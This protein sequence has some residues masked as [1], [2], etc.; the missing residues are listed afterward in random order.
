MAY[1]SLYG[2]LCLLL[3]RASPF[4]FRP[5]GGA[6]SRW[7]IRWP[8]RIRNLLAAPI[9]RLLAAGLILFMVLL[10]AEPVR[11]AGLSTAET[12]K[13]PLLGVVRPADWSLAALAVVFGLVDGFNPCA[14]WA[15]VYLLSLLV[16]L[17][18]R[19]RI[20]LLAGTFLLASGTLYFFF[21]AAWLNIFLALGYLRLL[22]IAIGAGALGVGIANLREVLRTRGALACHVQTLHSRQ[23]TSGRIEAIVRAPLTVATFFGIILLAFT[24]NAI[25]F[26][27][28]AALPAIFTHALSLRNLARWQ[29]YGYILLYDFFFML[30]DLIIFSLAVLTLETTIGTRYA[31]YGKLAGGVLLILLGVVLLFRP[32][33]LR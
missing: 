24:V 31:K 5:G 28:S 10:L 30:D 2:E 6:V 22:T 29:Y 3:V 15:L 14:M 17:K 27:C 19:R 20:W 11:A 12:V 33:L 32:D 8:D 26:A 13:L 9:N 21:M 4:F 16:S 18:D 23:T 7:R 25:E 1:S